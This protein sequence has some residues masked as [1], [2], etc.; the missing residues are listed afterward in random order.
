MISSKIP[1]RGQGTDESPQLHLMQ[2]RESCTVLPTTESQKAHS[3]ADSSQF[4]QDHL[5]RYDLVNSTSKQ[6]DRR[7]ASATLKDWGLET[8]GI[9]V[10]AVIII[11]IIVILRKYNGR[12][13]Q[14]W[15]HISLNSLVSW[16][17][18]LAKAC[19]I[20]SVSQGIGQLKWVW[21]SKR[22]RLLY[23][24]DVFDSASRGATGSAFLLWLVKGRDTALLGSLAMVLA[25]GFDPFIQNLVHYVPGSIDSPSEISLLGSTSLYN[26]VGPLSGGGLFYVD[27]ILKA[28]VYSALFNT[29]P[30]QPWAVPQY[31]CSTGN[32]TWAP[33]ATVEIRALC[34]NLTSTLSTS[35]TDGPGFTNCTVSL[36]SGVA[37][38]YL[39]GGGFARPMV[40]NTVSGSSKTFYKNSTFPVIQYILAIGS[41]DNPAVGGGISTQIGKS[42]QFVATECALQPTVRSFQ[43]SVIMGVYHETQLAEW[44]VLNDTVENLSFAYSFTPPWNES[45]GAEESQTFGLAFEAW[46]SLTFFL[47]YLFAG[48]VSAASDIFNFDPLNLGSSYATAD[49]LEAIFY[50][51]FTGTNCQDADQLSCTMKNVAAAMS[52]TIRDSAFTYS[53][54][55]QPTEFTKAKTTTGKAQIY[56][57]FVDVRWVWLTLPIIVWVLG[58]L[59]C[60][61]TAWMTHQAHIQTWMNSVLPLL[62]LHLHRDSTIDFQ[63][64]GDEIVGVQLREQTRN[65]SDASKCYSLVGCDN[66]LEGCIRIAKRAKAKLQPGP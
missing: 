16:L 49:A 53:T 24:L 47:N 48:Y 32:C 10:S 38:W 15:K 57:S 31:T 62:F 4:R 33:M 28:N 51:N 61:C 13:Q 18:T 14:D 21:F 22:S 8:A 45:L 55:Y 54:S 7:P 35:C 6:R 65:E 3:E 12:Q 64:G 66:S 26:T 39:T 43:S 30:A 9:I 11:A 2:P 29:N 40:I 52:K 56:A 27:P 50:G 41:N 25:I 37:L 59:S 46:K 63:G 20:F 23:D 17:S 60:L 44:P 58:A 34:S 36:N 5:V 42:T 19:V 1:S